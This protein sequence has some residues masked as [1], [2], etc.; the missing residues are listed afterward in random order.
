[1]DKLGGVVDFV[2]AGFTWNVPGMLKSQLGLLSTDL[3]LSLDRKK[4]V[5]ETIMTKRSLEASLRECWHAADLAH[6]PVT[7][8]E[9]EIIG[10]SISADAALIR[11]QNM[12]ER[13]NQIVLQAN[14]SLEREAD[15]LVPTIA[16]HHWVDESQCD[17]R[18]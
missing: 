9:Q 5:H 13:I 12:Q 1:M 14:S 3:Q 11:F 2:Q 16:F 15:R 18:P 7:T 4:I 8:A 10:A 6:L 17:L